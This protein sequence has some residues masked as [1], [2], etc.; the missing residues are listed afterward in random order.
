MSHE[1]KTSLSH[2]TNKEAEQRLQK[3]GKNQLPQSKKRSLFS[4]A[5]DVLRE[6]MLILLLVA[7]GVYILL[8]D[9]KEGIVLGLS[10]FVVIGISLYQRIR[11]ERALEA[12]KELSSPR[13]LV[14]RDSIAKKVPSFELVPDD[15]IHLSEGDRVPADGEVLESSNLK[16]DESLLTGESQTVRKM[17]GSQVFAGTL[18]VLGQAYVR[19]RFTG[20]STEMGKIGKVLSESKPSRLYLSKEIRGLTR[21]FAYSGVIVCITIT[22]LF[23]LTRG[24]WLEAILVGLATQLALLP[25]EFPVV[26]TVFMALG[27]WRL[28]KVQV[29][30]RRPEAIERLGAISTL[31]VDKTGTLTKNQMTIV[32]KNPVSNQVLKYGILATPKN[33]YDPMD[34]AFHQSLDKNEWP[35]EREAWTLVREYPLSPQLL[36]VTSVWQNPQSPKEHLFATKGAP[37]AIIKLC[38]LPKSDASTR[39]KQIEK[40][41]SL[42]QRVLGVA[43]C[44]VELDQTPESIEGLPF[45]WVGLVG[46]EDPLRK[47]VPGAIQSCHKAGVRV[48]MITG[49]YPQTAL[50]IA[51]KAGLSTNQKAITGNELRSMSD[52]EFLNQV[53]ICNVFSRMAPDQKL[54]IVK[55]LKDQGNVVAMTGDGVNDAP[56]LNRAD[57]GIAMGARGTD[58]AR[59]AS[60]VV[61]L[62]DNFTSIVA[63][64]RRGRMIFTNIKK[65]LAYI[66]TIHVPI[67]GLS[68]LPVFLGWP[69]ILL[70]VHIVLLELIIDPVCSLLF[71]SQEDDENSMDRPPRPLYSKLFQPKDFTRSLGQGVLILAVSA[72]AF[73]LYITMERGE[74]AARTMAFGILILSNLG[75]I[76]AD[77]TQGRPQ[78]IWRLAHSRLNLVILLGFALMLGVLFFVPTVYEF[79]KFSPVTPMMALEITLAAFVTSTVIGIWNWVRS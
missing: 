67:A 43:Q 63:G 14:I 13:A 77:L 8:G 35:A 51:E 61:L 70:P 72:T 71:E 60:D 23:A 10:I 56:S 53:Q 37:E 79:L 40:M 7:G 52:E 50:N 22:V 38:R 74:L 78:A 48:I 68:I 34:R 42:G 6:P 29:L 4:Q 1:I 76:V 32:Q 69:L 18:V 26:L 20:S 45:Q 36:A 73:W 16:V 41:A 2:L 33:P 27:A 12:L 59:E 24:G 58:V 65:A 9:V 47:E 19:V 46:L 28:S 54:K 55:A 5:L 17:D 66:I 30:V 15:L 31:C 39:L 57:V 44:T 62:D 75:L 3:F 25:E 49:D 21:L 64:I 11:S